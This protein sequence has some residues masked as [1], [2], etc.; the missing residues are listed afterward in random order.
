MS[1]ILAKNVA[2]VL[3]L[4]AEELIA[5]LKDSGGEFLPEEKVA[6]IIVAKFSEASTAA[7]KQAEEAARRKGQSEETKRLKRL[8]KSAGFDNPG[9]LIGDELFEA[10]VAFK[11]ES[12]GGGS[13]T[14]GSIDSLSKEDLAKLPIVKSLI[15]EAVQAGAQ[16]YESLKKDFDAKATEFEQFKSNVV[17][18][19]TKSIARKRFEA[20]LDKGGIILQVEGMDID[21]NERVDAA[22]ERFWNK[23]K[24]GLNKDDNPIL[25]N[26][27]GEERVDPAFGRPLD[28]DELA[29]MVAKPMYGV[30]TQNPNH[31]GSGVSQQ[32]NGKSTAWTPTMRFNNAQDYENYVT[33]ETDPKLRSEALRSWQHQ[34]SKAAGN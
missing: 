26:E 14:Q 2:S 15:G 8:V 13:A 4:D 18:S 10:F 27:D 7:T 32:Q 12:A 28:Y 30:S 11:D 17:E 3:N 31:G 1:E 25:L 21:R 22:F 6:K 16:K 19:K 24:I 34:Q 5:Q 23:N 33:N 29:V 20:A 9:N